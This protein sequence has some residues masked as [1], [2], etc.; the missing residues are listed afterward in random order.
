MG[1][2]SQ[3]WAPAW[4][5]EAL[6]LVQLAGKAGAPTSGAIFPRHCLLWVLLKGTGHSYCPLWCPQPHEPWAFNCVSQGQQVRDPESQPGWALGQGVGWERHGSSP[7]V[8]GW[9]LRALRG[10]ASEKTGTALCALVAVRRPHKWTPPPGDRAEAKQ[11]SRVL[12]TVSCQGQ[13]WPA[14]LSP[15]R[16]LRPWGCT[17]LVSGTTVLGW[18][19]GNPA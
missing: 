4:V 6:L 18:T 16:H 10:S 17:A 15:H 5:L 12:A 9:H 1:P 8:R 13:V 2:R 7:G 3:S 11:T 14:V 19:G